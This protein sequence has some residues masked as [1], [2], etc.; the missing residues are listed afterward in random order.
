MFK[1]KVLSCLDE[2]TANIYPLLPSA[3]AFIKEALKRGNGILVHCW[4]GRSRSASCIIAYLMSEEGMS[5]EE[6]YAFVKK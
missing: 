5:Y 3:I 4:A 2:S 6:A 1:Y